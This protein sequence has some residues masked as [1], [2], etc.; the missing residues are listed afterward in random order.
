MAHTNRISW[1]MAWSRARY[2]AGVGTWSSWPAVSERI[3]V[4]PA[5]Q[6]RPLPAPLSI[7]C[8]PLRL[9]PEQARHNR[10]RQSYTVCR[11]PPIVASPSPAYHGGRS[12]DEVDQLGQLLAYVALWL[13]APLRPSPPIMPLPHSVAHSAQTTLGPT[14]NSVRRQQSTSAMCV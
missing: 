8:W 7:N 1:K 13:I 2:V 11:K 9:Q 3:Q 10:L 6:S 14:A 5:R 12:Q 4:S